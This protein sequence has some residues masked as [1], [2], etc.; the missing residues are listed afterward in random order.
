MV[1][2]ASNQ[3][4][5]EHYNKEYKHYNVLGQYSNDINVAKY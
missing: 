5:N 3:D 1:T 2:N 4:S